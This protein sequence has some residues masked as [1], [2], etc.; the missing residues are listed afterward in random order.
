MR[1]YL[2]WRLGSTYYGALSSSTSCYYYY[3]YRSTYYEAPL[4]LSSSTSWH[5]HV[6]AAPLRKAR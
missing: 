3:F 5:S 1:L 2:L 4:T 6:T